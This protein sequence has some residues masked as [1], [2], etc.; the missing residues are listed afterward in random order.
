MMH[1]SSFRLL[2]RLCQV[3]A[4]IATDD[5]TRRVLEEMASEYGRKADDEDASDQPGQSSTTPARRAG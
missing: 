5:R 3:Q 1:R 4:S 2:A